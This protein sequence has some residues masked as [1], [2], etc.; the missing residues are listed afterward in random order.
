M[1]T[2]IDRILINGT[3]GSSTDA[4]A[5]LTYDNTTKIFGLLLDGTD[6]DS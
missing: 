6:S 5:L 3:D 2:T 1:K 4:G